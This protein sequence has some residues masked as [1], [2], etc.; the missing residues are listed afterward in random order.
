MREKSRPCAHGPRAESAPRQPPQTL[1]FV[2]CLSAFGVRPREGRGPASRARPGQRPS[3][4]GG[5]RRAGPR[6]RRSGAAWTRVPPRRPGGACVLAAQ[7]PL[8]FPSESFAVGTSPRCAGRRA[9]EAEGRAGRGAPGGVGLPAASPS[10]NPGPDAAPPAASRHRRRGTR[11]APRAGRGQLFPSDSAPSVGLS[12]PPT[13]AP[14]SHALPFHPSLV[15]T[16]PRQNIA[17]SRLQIWSLLNILFI[18]FY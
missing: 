8:A 10:S 12:R 6:A 15:C 17:T 1:T 7:R 2:Y 13:P 16:T 18:F 11:A 14:P 3:D 5:R 4:A 9:P